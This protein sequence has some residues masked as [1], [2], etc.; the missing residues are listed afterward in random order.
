VYHS[1][2]AFNAFIIQST[3]FFIHF[4]TAGFCT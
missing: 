1:T 4:V 2:T 3:N